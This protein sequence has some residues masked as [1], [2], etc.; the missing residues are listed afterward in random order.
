MITIPIPVEQTRTTDGIARYINSHYPSPQEKVKA[1][2]YWLAN[3]ISYDILRLENASEYYERQALI[4][5]TLRTRKALCQG[6]A[7]VFQE[8]C[9]KTGIPA[10]VVTGFVIPRNTPT[11]MTHAWA[12][13]RLNGQWYLFD[14][15][16]GAGYVDN[17]LYIRRVNDRH[18]MVSPETMIKT[19]MPFDPLW[20]FLPQPLTF[21][22][23]IYGKPKTAVRKPTFH[24]LDSLA[25]YEASSDKAQLIGT[26]RRMEA[27]RVIPPVVLE[28]LNHNKKQLSIALQND[29]ID[30]YN[31]A[32][33]S[34]NAGIEKF[35]TFI[36]YRNNHFMPQKNLAEVRQMMQSYTHSF[37]E[38]KAYLLKIRPLDNTNLLLNVESLHKTLDKALTHADQ[39][40]KFLERYIKT[41]PSQRSALFYRQSLAENK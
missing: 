19:H 41:P 20:Q 12:A 4:S 28:Q 5:Q 15:T 11:P 30:L 14:P 35:N 37:K 13:A 29:A 25:A 10:H 22:E 1:I 2:Y 33:N 9:T 3:N 6:Y 21:Q 39:Q 34:Y 16:W 18:F 7:E 26:I 40:E 17:N 36:R 31:A 8:L 38:A 24:V 23:F 32:V 27:N